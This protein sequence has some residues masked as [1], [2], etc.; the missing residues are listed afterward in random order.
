MKIYRKGNSAIFFLYV[1]IGKYF[2]KL[3]TLILNGIV[4][5]GW[6]VSFASVIQYARLPDWL[7]HMQRHRTTRNKENQKQTTF[8]KKN[9]DMTIQRQV[10]TVQALR[11]Q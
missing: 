3:F 10:L 4:F 1:D 11:N 7:R 8:S 9:T 6:Y 5:S 2:E